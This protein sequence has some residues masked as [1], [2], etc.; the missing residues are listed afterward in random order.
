[1]LGEA[2]PCPKISV[3]VEHG[4]DGG[5]ASGRKHAVQDDRT[6]R[7]FGTAPRATEVLA[8]CEFDYNE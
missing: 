2:S 3:D 4:A 6:D 1:V 5:R 8:R 7:R